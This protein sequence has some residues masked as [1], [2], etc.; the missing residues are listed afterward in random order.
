MYTFFWVT[1][2]KL[3][4]GTN[5]GSRRTDAN[6]DLVGVQVV[7]SDLAGNLSAVERDVAP[8]TGDQF[9]TC[10]RTETGTYKVALAELRR[11]PPK[12][13]LPRIE[14]DRIPA[15]QRRNSCTSGTLSVHPQNNNRRV[16]RGKGKSGPVD[17]NKKETG[18]MTTVDSGQ[19]S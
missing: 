3:N 5:L 19:C 9:D 18:Q 7:I 17:N 12:V 14:T 6:D 16:G 1:F 8:L 4:V 11:R 15:T 10:H 13:T 2:R